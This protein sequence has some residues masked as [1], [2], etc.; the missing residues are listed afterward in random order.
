MLQQSQGEGEG[1]LAGMVDVEE[2]EAVLPAEGE[3]DECN[4]AVPE[5][6]EAEPV[7]RWNGNHHWRTEGEGVGALTDIVE[8]GHTPLD[9]H[10]RD[11]HHHP[12]PVS[13]PWQP[14]ATHVHRS[15]ELHS[16]RF[17]IRASH[18][19]DDVGRLNANI[20][21]YESAVRSGSVAHTEPTHNAPDRNSAELAHSTQLG[22]CVFDSQ[23]VTSQ[24]HV[25][26]RVVTNHQGPEMRSDSSTEEY[27]QAAITNGYHSNHKDGSEIDDAD[28][29]VSF[30]DLRSRFE[31]EKSCDR[32]VKRSFSATKV[33][34]THSTVSTSSIKFQNNNESRRENDECTEPVTESVSD[35]KSRYVTEI[36]VN[37]SDTHE[38]EPAISVV[39]RESECS[40]E[41]T[42]HVTLRSSPATNSHTAEGEWGATELRQGAESVGMNSHTHDTRVSVDSCTYDTGMGV[43]SRTND[44]SVSLD[45]YTDD[46]VLSEDSR[47]DVKVSTA[48][49]VLSVSSVSQDDDT[50]DRLPGESVSSAT[51]DDRREEFR[52]REVPNELSP[53]EGEGV[54]D[55]EGI[56]EEDELQEGS[57]L[58]M[59][60]ESKSDFIFLCEVLPRFFIL[61]I[62]NKLLFV[63]LFLWICGDLCIF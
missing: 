44:I 36:S 10:S 21:E 55:E 59:G 47:T 28:T 13:F 42:R 52:D 12:S 8:E 23:N 22:T 25:S 30:T 18:E 48:K 63:R 43:D 60:Q 3:P 38:G 6:V 33:N 39:S 34:H 37:S 9:Q 62:F 2:D 24:N 17:A 16:G 57:V 27:Y 53:S 15:E 61:V 4:G 11:E 41:D 35:S 45:S 29:R 51:A 46:T 19:V 50:D 1:D 26:A 5:D 58:I 31:T 14:S 7:E 20:E 40:V 49:V 32:V 54:Y 56:V